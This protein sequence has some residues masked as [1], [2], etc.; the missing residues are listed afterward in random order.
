MAKLDDG[1]VVI[2]CLGTRKGIGKVPF[3]K[4]PGYEG[5]CMVMGAEFAERLIASSD[6]YEIAKPGKAVI[7]TEEEYNDMVEDQLADAGIISDVP[8]NI[9]GDVSTIPEEKPRRVRRKGRK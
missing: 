7:D 4:I 6:S 8:S 1:M 3:A 5:R 2:R 9:V